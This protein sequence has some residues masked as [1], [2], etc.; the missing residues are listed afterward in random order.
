MKVLYVISF[1]LIAL[2]SLIFGTLETALVTLCS[3]VD[4]INDYFIKI[5]M[6]LSSKINNK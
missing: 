2:I 3:G 5:L 4:V 1:W 6:D